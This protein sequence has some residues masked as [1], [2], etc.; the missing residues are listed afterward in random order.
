MRTVFRIARLA[1]VP[2]E[3]LLGSVLAEVVAS[4]APHVVLPPIV[5]SYASLNFGVILAGRSGGGKSATAAVTKD[6]IRVVPDQLRFGPNLA[7]SSPR[8]AM[9]TP[10]LS[11]GEGISAVFDRR[12]YDEL[13]AKIDAAKDDEDSK[14]SRLPASADHLLPPDRA[15]FSVDEIGALEAQTKRSGSSTLDV[16]LSAMMGEDLRTDGARVESRRRVDRMSYRA[17]FVIGAQPKRTGWMLAADG[18]GL[19]QRFC[20]FDAVDRYS[21]AVEY[22]PAE[23][24]D[25]LVDGWTSD[26]TQKLTITLP[27]AVYEHRD[28]PAGVESWSHRG[29]VTGRVV[30]AVARGVVRQVRADRSRVATGQADMDSHRNLLRLRLAAAVALLHGETAVTMDRWR[31]AGEILTLSDGVIASCREASAGVE[32]ERADLEAVRRDRAISAAET[33]RVDAAVGLV[34]DTA[35]GGHG[36]RWN[37]TTGAVAALSTKR[38]EA[39]N[40]A[41]AQLEATGQVVVVTE[42]RAKWIYLPE[43]APQGPTAAVSA[44]RPAP[45][46]P[47]QLEAMH[48]APRPAC[49]VTEEEQSRITA[50]LAELE[51]GAA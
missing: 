14:G 38:R 19:P 43:S 18:A 42:G 23:D 10:T 1:Q 36:H 12:P 34:H 33:D 7:A 41:L 21:P 11:S 8:T 37:G 24:D 40:D 13:R 27:T 48:H 51:G 2:P 49:M 15:R 46:S 16:L 3:A 35:A 28:L 5:G 47:E 31:V 26:D 45:V 29:E 39:A 4:T 44:P 25:A 50:E 9:A 20:W 6:A 22:S 30:V 17:A 32:Q